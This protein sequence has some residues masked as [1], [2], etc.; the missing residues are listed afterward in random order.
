MTP[1]MVARRLSQAWREGVTDAELH[2]RLYK[3]WRDR[4][5]AMGV[6]TL[7]GKRVLDIGCGDRAP[8]ALLAARD[9]ARVSA[10]DM[11]PIRL[12]RD[13][14]RMWLAL[15][16]ETGIRAAIR[17]V[18]RDLVHTRRYWRTLARLAGGPLPTQAVD[19][20]RGDAAA[21]PFEDGS[22]DVVFS[23]AVWEHL[24]DV[25]AATRELNR[26]LRAD[27]V[28]IIQIALF[29]ALQGGH[30]WEWHTLEAGARRATRPWEHL[31]PGHGPHPLFLNEWRED[32]YRGAFADAMVVVGWEDGEVRGEEFLT[33]DALA[34]LG[35]YTRRDLLLSWVTVWARP[36]G[37]A[38]ATSISSSEGGP[39]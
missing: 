28:A 32:Q 4:L 29:P 21:L 3:E 6:N 34:E 26:V 7:A 1:A 9:G 18:V 12:G 19:V 35:S 8:V 37:S 17:T 13:R 39:E 22:F 24:P 38:D 5:A 10:I 31:R 27:G 14:P 23:S 11:L 15:A 16:R 20:V 33:D 25:Q 2:V 30:Q 36:A